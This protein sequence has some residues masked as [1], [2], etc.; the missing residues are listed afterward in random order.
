M[1]VIKMSKFSFSTLHIYIY[2]RRDQAVGKDWIIPNTEVTLV[3]L[4]F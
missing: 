2:R 4:T 1:E 3:S